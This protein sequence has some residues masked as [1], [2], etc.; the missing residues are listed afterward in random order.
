M[1]QVELLDKKKK[2][3][4]AGEGG[5]PEMGHKERKKYQRAIDNSERKVQQQEE[6]IKAIEE[7]MQDPDFYKSPDVDQ[8]MK[9]LKEEKAELDRVMEL[10]E[11]AT[12]EFE[13]ALGGK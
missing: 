8:I 5:K 10:W 6:K 2:E 9:Q 3:A 4:K 1:R 13:I 11:K 7:K 12:E